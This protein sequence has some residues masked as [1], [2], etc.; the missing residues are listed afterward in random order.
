MK[1]NKNYFIVVKNYINYLV[2][3]FF[4]ENI[5][6]IIYFNKLIFNLY[7]KILIKFYL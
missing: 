3:F 1:L 2:I 5:N 6:I 7:I 4:N